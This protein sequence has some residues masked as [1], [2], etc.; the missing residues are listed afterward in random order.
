MS[1]W[2]D[3]GASV[4]MAVQA[5][6]GAGHSCE[7]RG[8]LHERA[9]TACRGGGPGRRAPWQ[10]SYKRMKLLPECK[11]ECGQWQS[12][13][14]QQGWREENRLP[15]GRQRGSVRVRRVTGTGAM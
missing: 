13:T 4:G 8:Q 2:G 14:L 6:Q 7:M 15:A 9:P 5:E 10:S 11:G 3:V 12:D 1:P